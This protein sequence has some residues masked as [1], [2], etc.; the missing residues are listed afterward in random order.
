MESQCSLSTRRLMT[1]KTCFCD[2]LVGRTSI[3]ICVML[4]E[5]QRI[6]LW[7]LSH[8]RQRDMKCPSA[9]RVGGCPRRRADATAGAA[10]R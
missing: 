9:A 2:R 8:G 4:H 10:W 7:D 1:G 6:S 5:G 3:R